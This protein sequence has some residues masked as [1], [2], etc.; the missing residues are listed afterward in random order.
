MPPGDAEH[1]ATA[2]FANHYCGFVAEFCP[3]APP[4]PTAALA[5]GLVILT[6]RGG[7]VR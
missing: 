7:P 1:P 4:A 5:A 6:P 2:F 3:S